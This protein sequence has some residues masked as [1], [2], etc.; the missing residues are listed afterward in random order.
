MPP[1]LGG[2]RSGT[3]TRRPV[4]SRRATVASSRMRFWKTPPDRTAVVSPR[5]AGPP[6]TGAGGGGGP[7]GGRGGGQGRVE[8]GGHMGG[9]GPG[10]DVGRRRAD[11][12]PRVHHEVR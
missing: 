5:R 4:S 10:H 2:T 7:P 1:S 12:R 9:R 11:G 6:A 3:S 8:A